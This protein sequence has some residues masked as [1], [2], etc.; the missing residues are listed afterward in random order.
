M[1]M[2]HHI[3]NEAFLATLAVTLNMANGQQNQQVVMESLSTDFDCH[4]CFTLQ[5]IGDTVHNV[6]LSGNITPSKATELNLQVG[7]LLKY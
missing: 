2:S 1:T 6:T 4:K 7:Q 3:R 5:E